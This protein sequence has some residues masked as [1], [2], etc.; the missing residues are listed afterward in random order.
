MPLIPLQHDDIPLGVPLPWHVTDSESKVIFER[1]RVV[2]N[3]PMLEQLLKLGLFRIAPE[4]RNEPGQG[5]QGERT[6]TSLTQIQLAP[7][8]LVQLQTLNSHQTE[9]FQVKVIGFHAPVSLL[10]TAPTNGG[11]LAFV[12]EGQQF[13]VRGFV[14]KD[15]VAYKTRV[16]KTNLSPFPY[17]HLAYPDSVQSMRIRSSARVSVE[18]ITA[19]NHGGKQI[20]SAKMIDLSVGGAKVLSTST[21][22]ELG[23]EVE[24]AFRINPAGLDVYLKVASKVRMVN[25]DEQSGQVATGVEFVDLSEQNRLYLT[26][27]VYQNLLKDSL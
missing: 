19:V 21:F 22:A 5:K 27:M 23:E 14:G 13:L 26:N 4:A 24:L 12:R 8:D 20:A 17:L 16:L 18:L 25:T 3:Q 6:T 2:D 9:R 11:K 15:A 1:G 10:V 7:G